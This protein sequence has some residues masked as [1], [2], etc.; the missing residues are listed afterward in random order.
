MNI[1]TARAALALATWI[2]CVTPGRSQ[3]SYDRIRNAAQEPQNWLTYSGDYNGWRYSRLDQISPANAGKLAVGW[4]FQSA[5]LGQFETTPLV[6]DGVLYGTGQDN[7]AFALDARTGR[8][9]WRY[10]RRLPDKVEAC[11]GMVNRG[12]AALGETLFMATLDA[13]VV[14]LD[15]KTGN[16]IWDVEAADYRQSYV[17]TVAPLVVKDKIIVGVAGGEYGV[18]GFIDAYYAATGKRAWRFYTVPGPG[19]PGHDTWTGNSW[20]TGGAPAWITGS[21]DPELNLIFWP[22]G[23]PSPSNN[24]GERKGDNLYSSSMLALDADTGELKWHY[25]FTPH[26]LHDYDATQIPVLLDAPW[27]GRPRKLLLQA[28][29][30]GFLY[31]LD[32]TS[33]E[34]L[35]AKPFFS[36]LT[37]AKGIGVDGRPVVA[38]GSEP[39]AEGTRTCPGA[40]GAT[41]WF[42]PSYSP[43]TGWLYVAVAEECDV[44]TSAPQKYHEGHDFIG[45]VYVQASGEQPSGA[46]RA[47]DPLTGEKKWEFKYFSPPNGGCL[48]TAGG[49]VFAGD[50]DGNFTAFDARSGKD[51]WHIQ[52]GAAIYSSP[53][54]YLL[55]GRQYVVIPA[56]AAL[57]AFVLPGR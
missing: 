49:V 6:I 20:K 3:V 39:T 42:S 43:Q 25:Q 38:P 23:N 2:L 4:A 17:F 36:G 41:N 21:Y 35:S 19:E 33:G 1:V 32:R 14:A 34:F 51:L 45:S 54:T 55:D 46:L 52:L 27:Q 5:S 30:N 57:F 50:S 37:W 10:Q 44:F 15:R 13:H 31:V 24:G 28:N 12:F 56:G 7:R 11:C 26:D 8:A 48:S 53:M 18:R 29:R 47:F 22:T 40:L 9:I 16:V